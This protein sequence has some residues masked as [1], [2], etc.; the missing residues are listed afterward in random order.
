[1]RRLKVTSIVKYELGNRVG[2]AVHYTATLADAHRSPFGQER[3]REK[4]GTTF[5]APQPPMIGHEHSTSVLQVR[6]H[7]RLRYLQTEAGGGATW[8]DRTLTKRRSEW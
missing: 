7:Q 6:A 2:K 3:M 4:S 5:G 1:M 8:N